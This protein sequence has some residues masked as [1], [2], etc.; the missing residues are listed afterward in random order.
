MRELL[1][2]LLD[3]LPPMP[4]RVCNWGEEIP[5][6]STVTLS[7]GDGSPVIAALEQ[8]DYVW[9]IELL[10]LPSSVLEKM[11]TTM[12]ET[13]PNLKHVRL[14]VGD[15]SEIAPVLPDS[16]LGG[17]APLLETFWLRGIP[18]PELPRILL[19][20]TN[21][22]LLELENIPDSGFFSPEAMITILSRCTK[23]ETLVLE[24]LS[25]HPHPDLT[26]QQNTSLARA[27]LPALTCFRF[28]GNG[29]YLRILFSRIE[30]PLVMLHGTISAD[31]FVHYAA[32][33][34]PPE[35]EFFYQYHLLECL[36]PVGEELGEE[37]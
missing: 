9:S 31:K 20:T 10:D 32:Y 17:S 8:Y 25:P 28:R 3:F 22:V 29:G 34:S 27:Y 11:A 5:S 4:I 24:F 1:P 14:W 37:E 7:L 30:N 23:L 18:F 36:V 16:F 19:S 35:L 26:S 21:L 15:D 33:L 12:Q 2:S 13:F 6:G